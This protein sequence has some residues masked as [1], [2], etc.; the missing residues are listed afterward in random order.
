VLSHLVGQRYRVRCVLLS[1]E[2]PVASAPGRVAAPGSGK[3]TP[4]M[5]PV[6][7]AAVEDLGAQVVQRVE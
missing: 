1:R 5:D 3:A 4:E 2:R 7:R 6:V